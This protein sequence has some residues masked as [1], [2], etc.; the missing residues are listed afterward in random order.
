MNQSLLQILVLLL[1]LYRKS[2]LRIRHYLTIPQLPPTYQSAATKLLYGRDDSA[3]INTMGVDVSLFD[4]LHSLLIP[5]FPR[6]HLGPHGSHQAGRSSCIDLRH[7]LA[8]TLQYLTGTMRQKTLCQLFGICQPSV[9][10]ILCKM[11]L[12]LLRV[13]SRDHDARIQWPRPEEMHTFADMIHDKHPDIPY[14]IFGFIDGLVLPC[15][16]HPDPLIQNAY[17]NGYQGQP[18]ISNVL[19]FQPDGAICYASINFPGSYHDSRV[20]RGVY[21]IVNDLQRTPDPYKLLGDSA[22]QQRTGKIITTK[23]N[24]QYSDDP[25]QRNLEAEANHQLSSARQAVE[26]G[27]RSFQSMFPRLKSPLKASD[28]RHNNLLI[29]V[30]LHFFNIRT[31]RIQNLNQIRSTYQ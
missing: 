10:N 28:F 14:G 7:E 17:Y 9:S 20:A 24:N 23:R 11:I 15:L 21:E 4:Y 3:F 16:N 8:L 1:L 18:T 6:D 31:R 2:Q 29:S 27:M 30:C 19:V 22:F 26:W 13:L 12:A 5:V 25:A